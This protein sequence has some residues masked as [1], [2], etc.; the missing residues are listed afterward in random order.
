MRKLIAGVHLTVRKIRQV[1]INQ[2]RLRFKSAVFSKRCLAC[3]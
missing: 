2:T 3:T 1:A